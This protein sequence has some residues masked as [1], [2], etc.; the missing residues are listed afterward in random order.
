MNKYGILLLICFPS[1]FGLAQ[2]R[3]GMSNSNCSPV[4][5]I[6]LNPANSVDS[7]AY[8][9]F[10]IAASNAYARTNF[11]YL[12]DF[13]MSQIVRP[14]LIQRAPTKF[15]TFL[16][17]T[18]E[19]NGPA[20]IF[21]KRTYG[22]GFFTRV[23]GVVDARRVPYELATAL[24]NGE[25]LDPKT[26]GE[27]M[28]Q[29]F[30]N[31][32]LSSMIWEEY[33]INL[34]K[35]IQRKQD[36]IIALGANVK[37]LS[38]INLTYQNIIAFNSYK[39]DDGSF[40]VS[41][42]EAKII[43]TDT[44]RKSGRGLGLDIGITYKIMQGYVDKYYANSK[45]SNCKQVN[46]NYKFSL[47]LR[48][49]GYIRFKKGTSKTQVIGSG[50]YDPN[51]YDTTF[52]DALQKNFRS[53]VTLNEP[54]TASMPTSL[55]GSAEK[56]FNDLFYVNVTVIKNLIPARVTGVQGPDLISICPRLENKNIEVAMPITFEKFIYPQ[57][58]FA[59]RFRGL[60]LGTDN[61]KPY[62]LRTDASAIS[63]YFG[64]SIN[65]YRNPVC[66]TKRIRVSDCVKF[67]SGKKNKAKG[68]KIF[69]LRKRH[70]SLV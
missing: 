11:G 6:F 59:L 24:L 4:T 56:N 54:I 63:F 16:Y 21:S 48:D 33:G 68:K 29:N 3:L 62:L 37:Y 39:N 8:W 70:K 61:L 49:L 30:S 66:D 13:K 1:L 7:K 51:K 45:Q 42:L 35:M 12:P 57:L 64:L 27:L 14:P 52:V 15:K 36:V 25:L 58:G 10:G 22:I 31:A 47:A 40:G 69:P 17:V 43:S 53:T 46:Y 67:L 60:I 18:A 55:V 44:A 50:F 65:L 41:N 23:R 32:K 28:G 9:Q 19:A 26:G 5:A 20:F 2:D 38:G 34:G